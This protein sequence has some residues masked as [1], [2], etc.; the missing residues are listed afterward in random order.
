MLFDLISK[1]NFLKFFN[2]FSVADSWGKIPSGMLSGNFYQY[3]NFDQ[4]LVSMHES[5]INNAKFKGQYCL[6]QIT[7]DGN[8]ISNSNFATTG[9]LGQIRVPVTALNHI[10][11][12]ETSLIG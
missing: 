4:C 9:F 8:S 2:I 11:K 1:D 7:S 10:A 6:S 5:S 12:N 3:G